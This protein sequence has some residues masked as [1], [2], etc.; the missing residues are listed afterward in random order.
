MRF[1]RR[2]PQEKPTGEREKGRTFLVYRRRGE[3]EFC[4]QS[5]SLSPILL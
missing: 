3:G 2:S 5:N 1:Y 4:A